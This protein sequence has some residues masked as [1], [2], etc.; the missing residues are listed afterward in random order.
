MK[1]T[2]DPNKPSEERIDA[3][4]KQIKQPYAELRAV[5]DTMLNWKN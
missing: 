3:E 2:T 1:T 5:S 4:L